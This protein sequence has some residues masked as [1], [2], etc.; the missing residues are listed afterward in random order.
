VGKTIVTSRMLD[1]VAAE[2][3]R[4]VYEVPVGFKWF[5]D[6]LLTGALGFAGEESAGASFVRFDGA[7]WSTD[8][9]GMTAALLAAE[10]TARTGR[11]PGEHYR[12]LT[13]ELGDPAYRRV[14]APATAAQK[15]RLAG[16]TPDLVAAGELAGE[17]IEAIVARAPGNGEPVGGLKVV[18]RNGWFAARPSGT[19][20]LYKLY[21]ESFLGE[22]HLELVLADAQAIVGAALAKVD[23]AART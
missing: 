17:T 11:D 22:D 19:E 9:D 1:R 2:L 6:G 20:D 4:S 5:A 3:G 21:A 13:R 7:P 15:A 16:L 8:K 12:A 10:I 18:T 23:A 14:D